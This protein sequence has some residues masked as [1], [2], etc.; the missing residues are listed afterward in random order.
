MAFTTIYIQ[1]GL[2]EERYRKAMRNLPPT[3]SSLRRDYV[4]LLQSAGFAE[5]SEH[6]LTAEFLETSRAWL[7]ARTRLDPDLRRIEGETHD[8][9]MRENRTNIA[10]VED[11]LLR[12]AMFVAGRES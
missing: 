9:R 3:V 12:R 7:S 11:G 1:P 4:E 8:R 10:A 2:S 6:D 5:V